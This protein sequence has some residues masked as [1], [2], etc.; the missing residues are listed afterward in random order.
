MKRY[1]PSMLLCILFLVLVKFL[2]KSENV[3]MMITGILIVLIWNIAI[4][5]PKYKNKKK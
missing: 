3:L 1:M 5:Y 4:W 2:T